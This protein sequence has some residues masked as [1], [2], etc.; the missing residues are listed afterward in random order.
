VILAALV[1][2]VQEHQPNAT[3]AT[4]DLLLNANP[5]R[6]SS[7]IA[8]SSNVSGETTPEPE[9]S[10]DLASSETSLQETPSAQKESFRSRGSRPKQ[11][12]TNIGK[13]LRGR[14]EQSHAMRETGHLW[15]ERPSAG[16]PCGVVVF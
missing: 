4:R 1:L 13:I 6:V 10:V 2:A 12:V 8:E 14:E 11:I 7:G 3:P 9:S 16:R 15:T 5:A